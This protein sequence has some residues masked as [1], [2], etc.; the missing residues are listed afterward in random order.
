VETPVSSTCS[1]TVC[2]YHALPWC[3]QQCFEIGITIVFQK[4]WKKLGD[5]ESWVAHTDLPISALHGLSQLRKLAAGR[6]EQHRR[7]LW[8]CEVSVRR[9]MDL[10]APGCCSKLGLS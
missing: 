9:R 5:A 3:H 7:G 6:E 10:P 2:R 4:D 8:E 1:T